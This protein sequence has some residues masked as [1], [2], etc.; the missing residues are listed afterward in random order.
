MIF[1]GV[2]QRTAANKNSRQ[3]SNVLQVP[4]N[5]F[6]RPSTSSHQNP[7]NVVSIPSTSSEQ[8]VA[9]AFTSKPST[10]SEQAATTD[11]IPEQSTSSYP[12]ITDLQWSDFDEEFT[13]DNLDQVFNWKLS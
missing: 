10:S 9:T 11:I 2:V 1:D 12:S 3:P 8:V 5:Y 6:S 7:V 13:S 4:E